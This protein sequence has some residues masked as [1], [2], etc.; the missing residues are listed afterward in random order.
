MINSVIHMH[1]G[2][3]ES[4]YIAHF[5]HVLNLADRLY[6]HASMRLHTS[7]MVYSYYTQYRIL[8]LL[9][10]QRERE[11]ARTRWCVRLFYVGKKALSEG[12][13]ASV[14]IQPISQKASMFIVAWMCS[15]MKCIRCMEVSDLFILPS[16]LASM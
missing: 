3:L 4:V 8:L 7:I 6:T 14:L 10:V 1:K 5:Q 9:R 15:R 11:R 12:L 13:T 16:L 2:F